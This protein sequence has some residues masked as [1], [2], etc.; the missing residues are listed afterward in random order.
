MRVHLMVLIA[1]PLFAQPVS[2]GVKAGVAFGDPLGGGR[3]S[4]P[5]LFG[6]TVEV[7]LPAGFAIEASALYRRLGQSYAFNYPT[8]PGVSTLV[9]SRVRGNSWE[10]PVI[11]KYYFKS[12]ESA[13]QPFFGS[14]WSLRTIGWNSDGSAT[15]TASTGQTVSQFHT[16]DRSGLNVGATFAAGVRLRTRRFSVI[17]EFRYTR[18]GGS[19][20]APRK[21]DGGFFL[22]FRF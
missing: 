14:G 8:E 1:A 2:V 22:G 10:F 18:W 15:T 19:D 16:S 4:S 13:W 6:P 9:S 11:G 17:P 21:N 20:G 5:F 7:R 3:E 12:R